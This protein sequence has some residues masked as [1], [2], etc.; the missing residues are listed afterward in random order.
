[1]AKRTSTQESIVLAFELL[2]RIPRYQKVTASQLR[3]Q[4]DAIG[5]RRD[6]R[7]IQRNLEMLSEHFQIDRDE[8]T[9][10]Y[11]YSWDKQ[12]KGLTMPNLSAHE[13]LLLLMAEAHLKNLLPSEVMTS[14][15]GFFTE[16]KRQL[17]PMSESVRERDWLDK[18]RVVS[19]TQPLLA[20]K[21]DNSVF[22][23][24]SEALFQDRL[25]QIEYRNARQQLR[26]ALVMPLGLAQQGPRLYLVCRFDGFENERS[27]AVH[28][29][30]KATV[31]SF[32][33]ER[34][35]SFQLSKYDADDRFG[36]G[37]GQLCQLKFNI[38]K[39]A[40]YH[41]LETPLAEDQTVVENEDYYVISATVINSLRLTRWL[42][43]FGD[44]VWDISYLE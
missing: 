23:S 15:D 31:S 19:D 10:P 12:A 5:I 1:M 32:N 3:D 17:M 26:Q 34:P 43:S 29:I 21:I 30:V 28:R 7:T 8:R 20:P 33:F 44:D 11:G 35:A 2:K 6:I 13:A 37:E 25:L 14:L 41:L 9:K 39:T 18:V 24:V 22:Q 38:A 4:L 42:N 36:F 27:L 40:G 16:A